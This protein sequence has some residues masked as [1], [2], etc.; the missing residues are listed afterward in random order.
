M[1]KNTGN[2]KK[3][4]TG[5]KAKCL[6]RVDSKATLVWGNAPLWS[7]I[8]SNYNLKEGDQMQNGYF[9]K[10][11][12][13]FRGAGRTIKKGFQSI[14]RKI[15]SGA[16][17]IGIKIA[18]KLVPAKWR[19]VAKACLPLLMKGKVKAALYAGITPATP[20]LAKLV[21]P[22][23]RP[24]LVATA[25][26]IAKADMHGAMSAV[27]L[28]GKSAL[29]EPVLA[30]KGMTMPALECAVRRFALP[31]V[32]GDYYNQLN[33]ISNKNV[34]NGKS[35]TGN[36]GPYRL[37]IRRI[38]IKDALAG[39]KTSKNDGRGTFAQ[40]IVHYP[41]K[42]IKCEFVFNADTVYCNTRNVD[43]SGAFWKTKSRKGRCCEKETYSAPRFTGSHY[44]PKNKHNKKVPFVTLM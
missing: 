39:R 29:V 21:S 10:V 36:S 6:S 16:I 22:Q 5:Y 33:I 13:W 15:K 7:S 31:V 20:I 18:I 38:G 26:K 43:M 19:A 3:Y 44:D 8:S 42:Q 32:D 11:G 24:M 25:A 12:K 1:R 2:N 28:T 23:Y 40:R 14:G 17:G 30:T 34:K 41:A 27:M 35:C 4:N 9:K 37:M